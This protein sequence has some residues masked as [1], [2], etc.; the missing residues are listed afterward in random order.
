MQG[1]DKKKHKKVEKRHKK[2][3]SK[4]EWNVQMIHAENKAKKSNNKVKIAI[5]D[6]GVELGE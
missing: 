1:K 3:E 6:S 4:V 2:S 5:L